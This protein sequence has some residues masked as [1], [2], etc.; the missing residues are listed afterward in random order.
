MCDWHDHRNLNALMKRQ[1]REYWKNR[2]LRN[3]KPTIVE[4]L[5]GW[6]KTRLTLLKGK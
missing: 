3:R 2:G 6:A 5:T 1:R 4:K